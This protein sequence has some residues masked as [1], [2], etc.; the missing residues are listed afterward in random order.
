MAIREVWSSFHEWENKSAFYIKVVEDN[1]LLMISVYITGEWTAKKTSCIL[2]ETEEYANTHQFHF[3]VLHPA[4][5]C[6]I[7]LIY[8]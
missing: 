3:V 1:S 4:A 5:V 8:T 7:L 2:E 6:L